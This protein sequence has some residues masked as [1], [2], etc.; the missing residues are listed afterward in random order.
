MVLDNGTRV[1]RLDR[2]AFRRPSGC[3]AVVAGAARGAAR[4]VPQFPIQSFG[5]WGRR[6]ESRPSPR[7][8]RPSVLPARILRV[9]DGAA[10]R[11]LELLSRW[12]RNAA[13]LPAVVQHSKC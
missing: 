9:Q 3:R 8:R 12:L 1:L 2:E 4:P 10:I 13:V 5:S 7:L 11:V 6:D